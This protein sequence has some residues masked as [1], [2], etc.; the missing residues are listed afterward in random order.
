MW[1][2]ASATRRANQV[3]SFS[4]REVSRSSAWICTHD[5]S[6]HVVWPAERPDSMKAL[7][8]ISKA[9]GS[10]VLLTATD[11]RTRCEIGDQQACLAYGLLAVRLSHAPPW[12]IARVPV[13]LLNPQWARV[14]VVLA[15]GAAAMTGLAVQMEGQAGVKQ[16]MQLAADV[17]RR[18]CNAG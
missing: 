14:V 15:R 4:A 7:D 2:T 18:A 12:C 10:P 3:R 8:E 9:A 1:R 6:L 11:V 16:D 13:V 5:H 17:M